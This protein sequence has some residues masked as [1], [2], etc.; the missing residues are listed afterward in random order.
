MSAARA[1]AKAAAAEQPVS[2]AVR[3]GL[4]AA[5]RDDRLWFE[6]HIGRSHRIRLRH[7]AET[8]LGR[9]PRP[10]PG[11]CELTIV[12][13][14]LPGAR[15]KVA[16]AW[17]AA[18]PPINAEALARELYEVGLASVPRL[19]ELEAVIRASH[20]MTDQGRDQ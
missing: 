14:V 10:A 7:W 18:Q 6:R 1:H 5:S 8:R 20:P 15:I 11:T 12:K 2:R 3:R 16:L 19:A 9:L 17:P 13:Q 4:D